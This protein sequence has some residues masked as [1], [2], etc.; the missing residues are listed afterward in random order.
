MA[1][2]LLSFLTAFFESAK[3]ALGKWRLRQSDE[4][5]VAW[6]W[7]FF[8]LPFL[9]PWLFVTGVPALGK[10]FWWVLLVSGVLNVVAAVLYMRAIKVSD[11]SLTAPMVAFT[12][13]FLLLTS[14]LMV[15]EF[16]GPA[17]ALGVGLI[18]AGSYLLRVRESSRGWFA[19]FRALMGD[20]G[21][22]TM[23]LVALIWSVTANLDKIGLKNSSPLFWAVAI[24]AFIALA[25]SPV[26]AFR[27]R[28]WERPSW[29]N[30]F[31]L[32]AIGAAGGLG[33]ICQML[34]IS[35]ALVPE[36]IALKRTSTILSVFWGHGLF[37]EKGLRDRLLGASVM[38]AGV[39]LIVFG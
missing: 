38:F 8:A 35:V 13:L 10:G 39:L 17:G 16:P 25:L 19:P 1:W 18:V 9:L 20:R 4:Y 14:P 7:R 28:G 23:L 29:S 36:V 26:V 33:T 11:L 22:R 21:P 32:A 24:N 12:P 31:G 6:A 15:G 3:D 30:A 27:L 34:A 37:G 5:L 2:V